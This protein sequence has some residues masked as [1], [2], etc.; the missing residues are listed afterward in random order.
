MVKVSFLDGMTTPVRTV[1]FLLAVPVSGVLA[2]RSARRK[3]VWGASII[4]ASGIPLIIAGL[5]HSVTDTALGGV[6]TY[7]SHKTIAA[8]VT[9]AK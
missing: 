4:A 9:T 7:R 8:R 2:D 5:G 6:D 1:G 3:V